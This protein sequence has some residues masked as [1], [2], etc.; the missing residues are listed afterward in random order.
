MEL[1]NLLS[2]DGGLLERKSDLAALVF[3]L[4]VNVVVEHTTQIHEVVIIDG[5]AGIQN[6]LLNK[7]PF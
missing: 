4:K 1:E 5:V 3:V 7:R 6:F 2:F